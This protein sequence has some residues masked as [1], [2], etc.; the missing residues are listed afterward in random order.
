MF[1]RTLCGLGLCLAVGLPATAAVTRF[2]IHTRE[3]V[4]GG[5][6]FGERGAYLRMAGRVH[7]ALAPA[8]DTRIVDLAHAAANSAGEVTFWADWEALTPADPRR[9]NGTVLYEVNNRGNKLALGMFCYGGGNDLSLPQALGDGWLLRQGFTVV[10]SGWDGELLPGGQR[11]LLHAPLARGIDGPLTGPV[12]C[13]VIVNEP[14]Q[15]TSVV[16]WPHHGSY[17]PVA[18]LLGEATLT[19]RE[20]PGDPR[21]LVPRERWT[22]HVVEVDSPNPTQLPRL[23][24]EV[25]DG[26][27]PGWIYELIYTAQDP[28]VM[29][30]GLAGVRDLL[31]ALRDGTGENNPFVTDGAPYLRHAVGFGVSQSGRFLR[32]FVASGFN[33]L[34]DSRQAAFDVVIPHVAGGGLGS[35][36]QR[37]AQPTRHGGQH[38]HHDT[39]TDRF[40][41]A[42]VR[43][44]DPL[45]GAVD[46]VCEGNPG[47]SQLTI[48][49]TQ[50]SAEYW[51]RA[52]SLP[53]TDPL[54]R[55]DAEADDRVRFYTFGGTQHGPAGYPPER[56]WGQQLPN[57]ADY[58]PFLRALLFKVQQELLSDTRPLRMPASVVPRIADGTLIPW[59][60]AVA[61]FP[62]IP[63]VNLPRT[64]REPFWLYWG[65]RWP[66]ERIA[67]VQP[68][69]VLGRYRVLVP[70]PDDNGIDQGCLLPPEV[71][72]PVGTYTGWNL[73][74]AEAGAE[75][76]LVSLVGSWIP[77]PATRQ[78]REAAGDPRASLEERY[79]THAEYLR[80]LTAEC[81]RLHRAGWLLAEDVERVT[82]LQAERTR[83]VFARF[84][85]A[86]GN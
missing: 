30:A 85:P 23:E 44:T 65:E 67:D 78:E 45:S 51:T 28:L 8:R 83:P 26:F 82:R 39:P 12:R 61:V 75:H 55:R 32:E 16:P 64:L 62:K 27:S 19:R 17:R 9:A 40:P 7:V 3:L 2:E 54:G 71:A 37:F 58:R 63:G 60:R 5:Q 57:P 81:E 35:F 68:P 49:H 53:H 43:Q 15:R 42:Y 22:L 73:R 50:S 29:G 36:N 4:A 34:P 48:L 38:D 84:D 69:G 56:G 6:P 24:L 46:A 80:R 31:A 10:W 70:R 41:F 25:V 1:F 52:G 21:V 76:E 20:R 74:R 72:V 47:T 33:E 13:E 59:P 77:F 79:G 86:L 66:T 11:L 18:A 14:T